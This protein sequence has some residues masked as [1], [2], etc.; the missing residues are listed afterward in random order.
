MLSQDGPGCK[1]RTLGGTGIP[2]QIFRHVVPSIVSHTARC[3][4][5]EGVWGT[6]T[7]SVGLIQ[8]LE[9]LGV[10]VCVWCLDN[11]LDI[12]LPQQVI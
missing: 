9:T 5:K 12:C 7:Y 3:G 8:N 2:P 10:C 6:S 11:L 4:L 1:L